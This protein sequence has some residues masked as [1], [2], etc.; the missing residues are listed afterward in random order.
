MQGE[1]CAYSN[2]LSNTLTPGQEVF[3]YLGYKEGDFPVSEM[4]SRDIMALVYVGLFD[5]R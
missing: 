2:L 4:I 1:W 5:E 3:N